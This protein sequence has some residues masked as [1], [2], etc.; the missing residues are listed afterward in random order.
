MEPSMSLLSITIEQSL[1]PL[2]K[3]LNHVYEMVLVINLVFEWKSTNI[4]WYSIEFDCYWIEA[5]L[6]TE[7]VSSIKLI[8]NDESELEIQQSLHQQ[9]EESPPKSTPNISLDYESPSSKKVYYNKK[10]KERLSLLLSQF[11]QQD[12]DD[13]F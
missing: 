5:T 1:E 11:H 6:T 4:S 13:L 7:D 9:C 12:D 8:D 10:R 2:Y 3:L